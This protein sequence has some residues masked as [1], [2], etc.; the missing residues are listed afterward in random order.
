MTYSIRIG[1]VGK[2]WM[3]VPRDWD[4]RGM[5]NVSIMDISPTPDDLYQGSQGNMIAYW[6]VDYREVQDYSIT[7]SV[8]LAPIRVV[9]DPNSIGSYDQ[10]SPAYQ[11]Y[12]QPS[13]RIESDHEQIVQ[14]AHQIV[15][16]ESNP[17]RQAQLI[18]E[19]V[20][21]NIEG[22]GEDGETALSTLEKRNGSCGGHSWLSVALLRSV[23]IPAR[24]VTGIHTKPDSSNEFYSGSFWEETLGTHVWSEFFLPGYGWIQSDA[25]D[26]ESFARISYLRIVLSHGEDI[27]LG[28]DHPLGT[29]AWF[30]VPNIDEIGS[31]DPPTQNPGESLTLTVEKLP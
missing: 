30:H 4:G 14:L 19:W 10:S 31:G 3:P 28:H 24:A 11:R 18:H 27:A 1:N 16:D 7:F 15:G 25:V 12:T 22:P 5:A 13:S 8:D 9:V 2:L 23:G 29:V 21:A 6:D 20:A 26:A 17:Y